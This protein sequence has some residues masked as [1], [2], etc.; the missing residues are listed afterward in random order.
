M[1]D[2]L[3]LI[4]SMFRPMAHGK[5]IRLRMQ[6]QDK[7]INENDEYAAIAL[8]NQIPMLH[9]DSRRIQQILINLVKNALK[10]TVR[11]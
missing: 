9:G 1:I 7:K 11:G 6:I 8:Q 4:L 2:V 5:Q 3:K 10:F